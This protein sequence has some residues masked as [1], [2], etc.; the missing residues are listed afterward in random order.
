MIIS[1]SRR[2]DIPAYYPDWFCNR[3]REGYGHEESS[4]KERPQSYIW[5]TLCQDFQDID[6]PVF[7]SGYPWKTGR[8]LS[9]CNMFPFPS[10][11]SSEQK[12]AS[13]ILKAV[14]Q[15]VGSV[16]R[17]PPYVFTPFSHRNTRQEPRQDS[18]I[19][20]DCPHADLSEKNYK[21]CPGKPFSQGIIVLIC[22]YTV[23]RRWPRLVRDFFLAGVALPPGRESSRITIVAKITAA[24]PARASKMSGACVAPL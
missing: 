24:I 1:A 23:R 7:C 6:L 13:G 4:H 17:R 15:F 9:L 18:R 16:K 20:D 11:R 22:C 8:T 12:R 21:R 2:T 19:P 3:I 14:H 5:D 10:S